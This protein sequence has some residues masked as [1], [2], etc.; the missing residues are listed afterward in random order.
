VLVFAIFE[1]TGTGQEN[2]HYVQEL[3]SVMRTTDR[4]ERT[5]GP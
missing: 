3:L 2:V 5:C 1:K 4:I